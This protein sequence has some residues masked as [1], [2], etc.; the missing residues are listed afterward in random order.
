V[1]PPFRAAAATG[2]SAGFA[3]GGSGIATAALIAFLFLA[4][5]GVVSRIRATRELSPRGILGSTIEH[6]G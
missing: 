3:P 1:P 5:Q 2:A 6:P 4:A